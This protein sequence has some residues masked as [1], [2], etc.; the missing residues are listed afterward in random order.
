MKIKL[1]IWTCFGAALPLLAGAVCP[2]PT[3]PSSPYETSRSVCGNNRQQS[4][5]ACDGQD[6]DDMTCGQ[7]GFGAGTLACKRSCEDFDRAGCGAPSTCGNNAT[8]G[9]EMCDGADINGLICED[10]GLGPGE[11]GCLP[12]CGDYDTRFCAPPPDC[13]DDD[14]NGRAEMCDGADL[15]GLSCRSFGFAEG[16]LR[17]AQDCLSFDTSSCVAGDF[18]A[19]LGQ[20]TSA[21]HDAY[22]G[23]DAYVGYDA[24][25]PDSARPDSAVP[26]D[27]SRYGAACS[28]DSQCTDQGTCLDAYGT[29]GVCWKLCSYGSE[30]SDFFYNPSAATCAA[31]DPSLPAVCHISSGQNAPCGNLLNSVCDEPAGLACAL[32]ADETGA[33]V[34]ICDP[35]DP[36]SS[37]AC[38]VTSDTNLCGC[39]GGDHCSV[40]MVAFDT[41]D[42]DAPEGICADQTSVGSWCGVDQTTGVISPCTDYQ[43]CTG[44]DDGDYDGICDAPD[45][46]FPDAGD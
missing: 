28:A 34:R 43:V 21:G 45:G 44:L 3:G 1:H 17:C 42:P 5:E 4:G 15:D 36:Y 30:C 35:S 22:A 20:D 8:E 41:G 29:G 9:V 31:L 19:G 7:L 2:A 12:N 24:S 13:G 14:I 40:D 46:G 32:T 33:C 6:L 11:L 38:S 10:L 39:S 27:P 37:T 26:W 25:R 16:E 23:Y 18:D